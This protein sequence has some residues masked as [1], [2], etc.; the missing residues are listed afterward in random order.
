M[1]QIFYATLAITPRTWKRTTGVSRRVMVKSQRDYYYEL[2]VAMVEAGMQQVAKDADLRMEITFYNTSARYCDCSNLLK[3]FE[4]AGQPSKWVK[5]GDIG[6]R[7]FW[8]D[9]Q[10]SDIHVKRVRN[11]YRNQI[12]VKVWEV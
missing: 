12:L 5:K 10:F 3:A 9:K 2:Y 6:Y 4:D 11:A 7:D 8:D 1:N